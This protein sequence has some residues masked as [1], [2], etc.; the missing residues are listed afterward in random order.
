MKQSKSS[1]LSKLALIELERELALNRLKNLN[2]AVY[3]LYKAEYWAPEDHLLLVREFMLALKKKRYEFI[4]LHIEK[5]SFITFHVWIPN[6]TF[7]HEDPGLKDFKES[8]Q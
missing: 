1:Y 8:I 6:E 3:T 4:K 7:P 5:N 2:F